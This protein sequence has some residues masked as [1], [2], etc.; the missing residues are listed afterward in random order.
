MVKKL[1]Y[2]S[3][4]P[5]F[6][7]CEN[8]LVNFWSSRALRN[9][10]EVSF[11][12]RDSDRYRSGL[13]ERVEID[14][15]TYPVQFM[16]PSGIDMIPD[17]WPLL[18]KRGAMAFSR[19]VLTLPLLTCEVVTLYRLFNRIRPDLI[20]INNGGYPAALSA[21][22]AALAA[23]FCG[24]DNIVMVVNNQAAGYRRF[25]RWLDFPV[26]MMVAYSVTKFITGSESAARQLKRVLRLTECKVQ[27][28]HNGVLLRQTTESREETGKRLS[29]EHFDGI[30]Y[31]V[32]AIMEPRKGHQVL[33]DAMV[34]ILEGTPDHCLDFK[35]LL[36]G[37]GPLSDELKAFVVENGLSDYCIFSG[38]EANVINFMALLDIL[39]LPSIGN[40]DFPN[41]IIE[42]MALGKPVIAS[43]LAGTPEQVVDGET[44]ILFTPKDVGQLAAAI[45]SLENDEQLRLQMGQAG[46]ERF[47]KHFTAAAAVENY[48]S[49]Y[50]STSK[51]LPV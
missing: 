23:K 51:G 50:N 6:A 37:D 29:L 1:H 27:T 49:F 12:Y 3:D 31:G 28:I 42:A 10:Y 40:E 45:I 46:L 14:F 48:L 30:L 32:V 9:Q 21:R 8:M 47:Q 25:T 4:C 5:F 7:G 22:A 2:H 13:H 18:M 39:I 44:G 33:L 20:H 41:V 24:V 35:V 17:T 19:I 26:D 34:R 16:D 36:E 11:S 15:L 38:E 43:R